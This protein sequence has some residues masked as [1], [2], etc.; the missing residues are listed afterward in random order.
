MGSRSELLLWE[1]PAAPPQVPQ[2]VH[3]SCLPTG[4]ALLF[5]VAFSTCYRMNSEVAALSPKTQNP[6]IPQLRLWDAPAHP[7]SSFHL[8]LQ[9]SGILP[10][11]FKLN[12]PFITPSPH[13]SMLCPVQAAPKP[14]QGSGAHKESCNRKGSAV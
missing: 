14:E 2:I 7:S 3:F 12:A 10:W 11:D 4:T 5:Y 13:L 8:P 1:G 9:Y 6:T